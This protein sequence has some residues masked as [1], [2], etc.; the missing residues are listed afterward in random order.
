MQPVAKP[1]KKP[2]TEKPKLLKI[3]K[4]V[5]DNNIKKIKKDSLVDLRLKA[6]EISLYF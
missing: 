3:R 4:I 1:H 5:T 6:F 2:I